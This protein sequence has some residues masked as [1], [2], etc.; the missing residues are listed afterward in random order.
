MT[1]EA[2]IAINLMKVI[3]ASRAALGARLVGCVAHCLQS[4]WRNS[5]E[6]SS[7]IFEVKRLGA[8]PAAPPAG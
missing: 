3:P 2:D 6:S 7:T 4:A 1:S 8:P 5:A